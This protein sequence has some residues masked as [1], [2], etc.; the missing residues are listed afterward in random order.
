[1]HGIPIENEFTCVGYPD[2]LKIDAST[3]FTASK[4]LVA[5]RNP[6]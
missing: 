5:D 6:N 3:K 2:F 1:M 4:M